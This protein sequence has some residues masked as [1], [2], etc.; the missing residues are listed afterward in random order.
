VQGRKEKEEGV[1][2]RQ[3]FL[4]LVGKEKWG[5]GGGGGSAGI[6]VLFFRF[7]SVDDERQ[8][9]REEVWSVRAQP[10][11]PQKRSRLLPQSTDGSEREKGKKGGKA[12]VC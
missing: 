3:S 5:G 7:L 2:G 1:V 11:Y 6:G 8:E 10:S 9:E 4:S 12:E